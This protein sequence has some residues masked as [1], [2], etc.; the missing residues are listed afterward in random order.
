MID[1]E[2]KVTIAH[3]NKINTNQRAIL[4]Y[5]PLFTKKIEKLTFQPLLVG[6]MDKKNG[7]D[8]YLYAEKA[9]KN[10]DAARAETFVDQSG[11]RG[12]IA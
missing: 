3:I 7:H 5:P 8:I 12:L 9:L 6:L 4:E 11:L 2:K 1:T 10:L